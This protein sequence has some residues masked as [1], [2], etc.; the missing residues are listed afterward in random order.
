MK[1]EKEMKEKYVR[2]LHLLLKEMLEIE[3]IY[4]ENLE[5][6]RKVGGG[7]TYL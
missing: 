1:T 3:R 6:V 5:Q 2:Q 7:W 4:V